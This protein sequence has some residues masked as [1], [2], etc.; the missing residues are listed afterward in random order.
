ME[1]STLI[2]QKT[3]KSPEGRSFHGSVRNESIHRPSIKYTNQNVTYIA[4][5]GDE[6]VSSHHQNDSKA[7]SVNISGSKY[8][9]QNYLK[10]LDE[11]INERF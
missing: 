11:Q 9:Q 1:D 2:Y 3:H 10:N 5:G 8:V 4:V 7:K 6:Q